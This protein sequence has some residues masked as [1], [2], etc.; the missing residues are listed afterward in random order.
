MRCSSCGC[1][2]TQVIET[3]DRGWKIRRRRRCANCKRRFTTDE[4]TRPER[5]SR[6][7]VGE[8]PKKRGWQKVRRTVE[9]RSNER[10][11][12][13]HI[14]PERFVLTY[15]PKRDPHAK[16]NLM[17][18]NSAEH[19]VKTSADAKLCRGDKLGY[20]A[21]LTANNWPME[22]VN[23]ALAHYGLK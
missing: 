3:D 23:A 4:R 5:L 11:I 20:I 16:I 18:L 13:D 2:T 21:V 9:G 6:K 22:K 1:P 14:V 19:G 17:W 15:C 8:R 7:W 10:N 12:L